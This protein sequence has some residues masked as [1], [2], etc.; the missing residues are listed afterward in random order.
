MKFIYPDS[1]VIKHGEQE[2]YVGEDSVDE[3]KDTLNFVTLDHA[4]NFYE[5]DAEDYLDFINETFKESNLCIQGPITLETSYNPLI[6]LDKKYIDYLVP[7]IMKT[8]GKDILM[9]ASML[10]T[11]DSMD[12]TQLNSQY[13]YQLISTGLQVIMNSED[14]LNAF[15]E[16]DSE[17]YV[18]AIQHIVKAGLDETIAK[19]QE[20]LIELAT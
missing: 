6:Y 18:D 1:Y 20:G 10:S 16:I 2:L 7:E 9:I 15:L 11:D 12:S 4:M 17:N 3:E 5:E 14:K 19:V 8:H 13:I